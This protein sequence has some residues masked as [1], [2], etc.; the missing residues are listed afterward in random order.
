[1]IRPSLR[2]LVAAATFAAVHDPALADRV[3]LA[4]GRILEGRFTFVDGVAGDPF[5]D[6]Q[7]GERPSG[8]ILVCDDGLTRTMVS[9]RKVVKVEPAPVD[10]G[11]ERLTIPQRIPEKGRR[12]AGFSTPCGMRQRWASTSEFHS[13]GAW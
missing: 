1:M 5:A 6:E 4:D 13:T 3:E 2:I 11:M 8:P 10:L 12:V 7:E 9:K